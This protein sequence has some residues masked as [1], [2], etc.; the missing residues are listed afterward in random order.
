MYGSHI[1]EFNKCVD[2]ISHPARTHSRPKP[3]LLLALRSLFLLCSLPL[4]YVGAQRADL[5][6][7]LIKGSQNEDG[8]GLEKLI[9]LGVYTCGFPLHDGD[10]G[11]KSEKLDDKEGVSNRVRYTSPT[12]QRPPPVPGHRPSLTSSDGFVDANAVDAEAVTKEEAPPPSNCRYRT[13]A[14]LYRTWGSVRSLFSSSGLKLLWW[15]T[16]INAIRDYFGSKVALYFVFLDT[17]TTFLYVPAILGLLVLLYGLINVA[18]TD[19]FESDFC[20]TNYTLCAECNTCQ[21]VGIKSQCSAYKASHVFDNELTMW[22]GVVMAVWSTTFLDFWKRVRTHHVFRWAVPL[23]HAVHRTRPEF[24]GRREWFD[25][26]IKATSKKDLVRP[27]PLIELNESEERDATKC[28]HEVQCKHCSRTCFCDREIRKWTTY[29]E[30]HRCK[31]MG[32]SEK[33]VGCPELVCTDCES[34]VDANGVLK[35]PNASYFNSMKQTALYFKQ[36]AT[37]TA[38]DVKQSA[39][40]ILTFNRQSIVNADENHI[41]I[42]GMTCKRHAKVK[43]HVRGGRHTASLSV[44]LFFVLLAILFMFSIAHLPSGRTNEHWK[45]QF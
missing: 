19:Q 36:T 45:E 44:T 32:C 30:S 5:T 4:I 41:E 3:A 18:I 14:H 15:P 20:S 11:L 6:W 24:V 42:A 38:M 9:H 34:N 2:S 7:E 21:P 28:S 23:D 25:Q 40:G 35:D 10:L 22:F 8:N 12:K 1:K 13:R 33:V 37:Q 27:E 39:V 17:Y 29:C 26:Y 16:P 43:W 31:T